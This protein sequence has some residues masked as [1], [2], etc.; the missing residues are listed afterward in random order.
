V[1]AGIV[2]IR[3]PEDLPMLLQRADSALYA[4]KRESRDRTVSW[5]PER[6]PRALSTG[7]SVAA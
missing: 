1:S 4:A 2:S 6:D 5:P 7:E 3:D